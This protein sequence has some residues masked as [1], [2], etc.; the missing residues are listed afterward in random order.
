M[1]CGILCA[2][3]CPCPNTTTTRFHVFTKCGLCLR[4]RGGLLVAVFA[5]CVPPNQPEC[6]PSEKWEFFVYF[7]HLAWF[8]KLVRVASVNIACSFPYPLIEP[9]N[10]PPKA[11]LRAFAH[12]ADWRL[13]SPDHGEPF[14]MLSIG[15]VRFFC[16][17]C[18]SCLV[19]E[20]G[21]SSL[22]KR[23]SQPTIPAY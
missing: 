17:F 19:Q 18:A 3:T 12:G 2:Q 21:T 14:P 9:T 15:K 10:D 4:K 16:L 8:K 22:G 7:V 13:Q 6:Y 23:G 1:F 5:C 11:P 20:S